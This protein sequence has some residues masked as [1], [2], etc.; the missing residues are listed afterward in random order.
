M[1]KTILLDI[2]AQPGAKKTEISG[3]HNGKIKIRLQA[4]PVDGQ[5]NK[6]LTIFIAKLL[7]LKQKEVQLIHGAK[8]REKIFSLPETEAVMTLLKKFSIPFRI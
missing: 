3:L 8:C 6:A 2:Y 4:F 1:V 5:A 7:G